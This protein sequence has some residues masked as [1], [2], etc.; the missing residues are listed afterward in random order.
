VNFSIADA[1]YRHYTSIKIILYHLLDVHKKAVLVSF[2]TRNIIFLNIFKVTFQTLGC[3]IGKNEPND[4]KVVVKYFIF[5]QCC[6]ESF[7]EIR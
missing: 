5:C 6:R 1:I 7:N 2:E 3:A 4:V